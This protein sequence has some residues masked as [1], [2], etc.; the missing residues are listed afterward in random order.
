MPQNISKNAQTDVMML[1]TN[2]IKVSTRTFSS[3]VISNSSLPQLN[4]T[5]GLTATISVL[6]VSGILFIFLITCLVVIIVKLN[7][8]L[9]LHVMTNKVTYK[10][11]PDNQEGTEGNSMGSEYD[12]TQLLHIKENV[13]NGMTDN[14]NTNLS[15]VNIQSNIAYDNKGQQ[16]GTNRGRSIEVDAFIMDNNIAYKTSGYTKM[17]SLCI[18]R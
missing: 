11:T 18:L 14:M 10:N 5:S 2:A 4:V 17:V 3:I 13:S 16:T 7:V 15:S 12:N 6:I 8:K 9:R 1:R